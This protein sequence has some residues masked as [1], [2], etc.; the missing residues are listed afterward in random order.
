MNN[1]N[2][3]LAEA[4]YLAMGEKNI[5]KVEKCLHPNVKFTT[6]LGK[7]EGKEQLLE[8]ARGFTSFFKTLTIRTKFGSGDQA[9]IVYDLEA[10]FG[11]LPTAALMT[12]KENL[13]S[14]IEL[15]Y[16]A[17]PFEKK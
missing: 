3:V 4:Y 2:L 7:I 10:P 1:D 5:E 14:K 16:D 8:A 15:F 13:I 11:H 12:F 17:R 9:V 6:P